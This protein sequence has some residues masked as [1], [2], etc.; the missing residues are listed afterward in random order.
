MYDRAIEA[1]ITSVDAKLDRWFI[2]KM[3]D[4]DDDAKNVGHDF[5][6]IDRALHIFQVRACFYA[7]VCH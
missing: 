6:R 5:S 1:R 4:S 2:R 7:L 3:W